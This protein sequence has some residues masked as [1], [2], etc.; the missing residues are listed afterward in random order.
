MVDDKTG[1]QYRAYAEDILRTLCS[2][3]YLAEPGTNGDFILMHS[4]GAV[5]FNSEIDGAICYA[6]YYF[7]EAIQRYKAL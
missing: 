3:D 7:L 1:A 4:T 5:P 2:A 6:D